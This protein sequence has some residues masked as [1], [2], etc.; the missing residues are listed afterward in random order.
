M[1]SEIARMARASVTTTLSRTLGIRLALG[2]AGGRKSSVRNSQKASPLA[3]SVM[4]LNSV[5]TLQRTSSAAATMRK[6]V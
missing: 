5:R 6:P 2:R 4:G 3:A 1:D